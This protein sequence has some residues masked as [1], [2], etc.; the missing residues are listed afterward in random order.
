M[1]KSVSTNHCVS[2]QA[3]S[4][5][6]LRRPMNAEP[7]KASDAVLQRVE[8]GKHA[9]LKQGTRPIR[10]AEAEA[11]EQRGQRGLHGHLR[12]RHAH[13]VPAAR[14]IWLVPLHLQQCAASRTAER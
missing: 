4:D 6:A 5:H 12:L 11:R 9:A 2:P 13:A 14:G 3:Q 1:R 8:H 7:R 10:Q